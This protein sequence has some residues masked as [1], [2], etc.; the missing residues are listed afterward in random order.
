GGDNLCGLPIQPFQPF[1]PCMIRLLSSAYGAVAAWRGQWYGRDPQRRRRLSRPVISVGSLRVGG[2]GKTPVV[3]H[4][5]RLLLESGERPA[6]LTRGYARQIAP[7]G[8]TVVSDGVAVR[9]A[10]AE[11][12]DEPLL[13]AHAGA[14]AA[15]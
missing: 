8:V 10:V 13:L 1:L 14:G 7:D 15:V 2:S 9:A 11:A 12:G 5:A 4:L 6:V 3:G